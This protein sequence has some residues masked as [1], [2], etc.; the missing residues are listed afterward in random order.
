L[1]ERDLDMESLE[2]GFDLRAAT[3][4]SIYGGG[5]ALW[6]S[7]GNNRTSIAGGLTRTIDRRFFLGLFG[8]TLSYQRRGIGYFSP[9]RFSVFEVTAGYN[10]ESTRW[11]GSLSGG[12]GVQQV[13]RRGAAQSEW[14][15]EGRLGPRW[16]SGNRIELFGLVT[17]S[18]VSS[19]SG[20]FRYRSAGLAVRLGL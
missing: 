12:V 19:T 5:G 17:N 6:L 16:G 20:A 1:I 4:L 15:V 18:A 2:G 14:H 8:R 13:G 7:D 3:G 10:H 11:I 9:D